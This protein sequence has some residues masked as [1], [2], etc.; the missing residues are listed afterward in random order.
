M[1]SRSRKE[2][3]AYARKA[4]AA[5]KFLWGTALAYLFVRG[6]GSGFRNNKIMDGCFLNPEPYP[7]KY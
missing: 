1:I 2:R 5:G 7:L 3:F 4:S 6:Q